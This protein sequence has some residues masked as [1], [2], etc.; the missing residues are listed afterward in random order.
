[1]ILTTFIHYTL[2]QSSNNYDIDHFY[3]FYNNSVPYVK[4]SSSNKYFVKPHSTPRNQTAPTDQ[5]GNPCQCGVHVHPASSTAAA[6][7]TATTHAEV[8]R[9][10]Q[11]ALGLG[12]TGGT[13]V[14]RANIH[15]PLRNDAYA[16]TSIPT[17]TAATPIFVPGNGNGN[18]GGTSSTASAGRTSTASSSPFATDATDT[19]D[20]PFEVV[21]FVVLVLLEIVGTTCVFS[22]SNFLTDPIFSS[23]PEW[24]FRRF[25]PRRKRSIQNVGA[26]A[27]IRSGGVR[28]VT[29]ARVWLVGH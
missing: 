22:L 10:L 11:S 2:Q 26:H 28:V 13:D 23:F 4:R 21:K 19:A 5:Y 16:T 15:V 29:W 9:L 7:P 27:Y 24:C 18:G 6:A 14:L 3:P 8:E 1:M 17:A 20:Y 12:T 25:L